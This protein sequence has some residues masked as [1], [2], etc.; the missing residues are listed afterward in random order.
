[1]SPIWTNP[2]GSRLN[3][4]ESDVPDS[5][6]RIS[7]HT[8]EFLREIG[9]RGGR[10]RARRHTRSELATWGGIRH[11]ITQKKNSLGRENAGAAGHL[12]R[13]TVEECLRLRAKD[14]KGLDSDTRVS[15]RRG[16]T[17]LI[18]R[19]AYDLILTISG[20]GLPRGGVTTEIGLKERPVHG[21]PKA[22][23][24]TIT[25]TELQ[26][27]ECGRAVRNVYLSIDYRWHCQKCG[28]LTWANGTGL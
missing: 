14:V 11:G 22:S 16:Y 18:R 28:G 13:R 3:V 21:W 17:A 2:D 7:P 8:R 15:L 23:G 5:R 6:H 27:A 10:E 1:M 19:M 20:P 24:R 25:A 26:C 4:P 12:R 9:K